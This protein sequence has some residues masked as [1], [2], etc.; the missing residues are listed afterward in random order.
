MKK[1][2]K[3]IL[4]FLVII[5]A[6]VMAPAFPAGENIPTDMDGRITVEAKVKYSKKKA[7]KKLWK[8]LEK[9]DMLGEGMD[10]MYDGSKKR[11]YLFRY[12]YNGNPDMTLTYGWYYVDKK[13]GKI[14][15]WF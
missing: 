2:K 1:I 7:E 10:I 14:T 5:M 3:K 13:T 9:R 12:F 4:M 15:K 11:K 6:A 8:Y